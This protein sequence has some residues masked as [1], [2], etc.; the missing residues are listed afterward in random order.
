[1]WFLTFMSKKKPIFNTLN[2][3]YSDITLFQTRL[4]NNK[5]IPSSSV[6]QT[7]E[8]LQFA[9][10]LVDFLKRGSYLNLSKSNEESTL[11]LLK[12]Y[13]SGLNRKQLVD[14]SGLTSRQ[15]YYASLKV[16][17]SLESRFPTGL[18]SLWKTRQFQVIE[19]Y[20][21]VNSDEV[22][23][24]IETISNSILVQFVP[25]LLDKKANE[26]YQTH[27]I[28][29]KSTNEL[30]CS[31]Y[32]VLEVE[33]QIKQYLLENLEDIKVWGSLTRYHTLNKSFSADLMIELQKKN[34]P[35]Q[36]TVEFERV[37]GV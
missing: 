16:E 14:L 37:E 24:I 26:L 32:K 36:T 12:L 7:V 18:L 35:K 11:S 20:L 23:S 6:L 33:K 5:H 13:R 2:Q 10:T 19:E 3:I 34:F 1:V 4:E 17:E 29:N 27:L 22:S 25:S 31:L 15:V 9:K 8:D 30:V 28:R 21:Q